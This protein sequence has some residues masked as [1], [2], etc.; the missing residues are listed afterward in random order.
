MSFSEARNIRQVWCGSMI[1]R[2]RKNLKRTITALLPVAVA[3]SN[4]FAGD[5]YDAES[6]VVTIPLVKVGDMFYTNVRAS[7]DE[8]LSVGNFESVYTYDIYDAATNRLFIPSVNAY[9]TTFKNVLITVGDV[10]SVA[11][12]AS[13]SSPHYSYVADAIPDLRHYYQF[14]DEGTNS[15]IFSTIVTS[16]DLDNDGMDDILIHLWRFANKLGEVDQAPVANTLVSLLND[17]NGRFREGNEELF[18]QRYLQLSGATR[19]VRLADING[20]GRLDVLYA[21]NQED[22]RT[23]SPPSLWRAW[24]QVLI[25]GDDQLYSLASFGKEDFHHSVGFG[26]SDAGA[27]DALIVTGNAADQSFR[28]SGGGFSAGELYPEVTMGTFAMWPEP[29]LGMPTTHMLTNPCS[30]TIGCSLIFHYKEPNRGWQRSLTFEFQSVRPVRMLAWNGDI[31]ENTLYE[32]KD[33]SL[34]GGGFS[35]SKICQLTPD[36]APVAIAHLTAGLAGVP[37]D[38]I[39]K[40]GDLGIYGTYLGFSLGGGKAEE[41]SLNIDNEVTNRNSN[42]FDCKDVNLDGYADIITYEYAVGGKPIVYLND[43]IGGFK[44]VQSTAFPAAP[45]AWGGVAT[46]M[47]LEVTGDSLPDLLVWPANGVRAGAEEI[48]PVLYIGRHPLTN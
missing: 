34:I 36:A 38:G 41:I 48:N 46:S 19:N 9:G 27:V 39:Y 12:G 5:I 33:V 15:K 43:R 1:Y 21:T 35:D 22:G 29:Q 45:S 17:G 11:S 42:F 14:V 8:V 20:D 31:G 44:K 40:E 18:G 23:A 32:Y 47:F 28:Y 7:V 24:P 16:T 37:V 26:I 30:P 2:L 6:N 25:S 10:H 3:C 13:L 4:V